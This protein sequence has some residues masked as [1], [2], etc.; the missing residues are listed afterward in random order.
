MGNTNLCMRSNVVGMKKNNIHRSIVFCFKTCPK[1]SLLLALYTI[2]I[3]CIPGVTLLIYNEFIS[4]VTSNHYRATSI[5]LFFYI[6]SLSLE[7]LCQIIYDQY[8]IN[9]FTL[10]RFEKKIKLIF[11]HICSKLSLDDYLLAKSEN[12]ILRAK[13]ASVNIFRLYQV[14]MEL[15]SALISM[16]IIG[17]IITT[18]NKYLLPF[19]I[20][21]VFAIIVEEI[22]K[23]K[24]KK[25]VFHKSTQLIKEEEHI[26]SQIITPSNLKD[27]QVTRCSNFVYAKWKAARN[28]RLDIKRRGVK[29]ESFFSLLLNIIRIMGTSF[30]ILIAVSLYLNKAIDASSLSIFVISF[31]KAVTVSTNLISLAGDVSEFALLVQPFFDFEHSI[32]SRQDKHYPLQN[33]RHKVIDCNKLSYCYPNANINTLNN[34]SFTINEGD[35]VSIIG[36]N[37][38]GKSTLVKILLGILQPTSGNIICNGDILEYSSYLP[39]EFNCYHISLWDNFSLGRQINKDFVLEKTKSL[40][41]SILNFEEIIGTTFGG[42]DLSAGE[43]QRV[44]IIR[45]IV[46]DSKIIIFD[47]P[48]SNIDAIQE[49]QI[50]KELLSLKGEKTVILISHRLALT[51][52]SNK[53]IVLKNGGIVEQGTHQDL[54]K[55]NGE[56]YNLWNAQTSLYI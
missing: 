11:F 15:L 56:Y 50:Y 12:R 6:F 47:E 31:N 35:F 5:V 27:I 32:S 53:I 3:S 26:Y 34:I 21:S 41:L 55:M 39:Q 49:S 10:P 54:L 24:I 25:N 38:S 22:V 33:I 29:R 44:A 52:Y 23:N 14:I 42:I 20:L 51:P 28:R 4:N 30:G 45:S 13:N 1:D 19:Y 9:Y 17:G 2:A 36:E 43:K 16:F 48:T 18:I 8:F 7:H 46:G 40:N 37:G